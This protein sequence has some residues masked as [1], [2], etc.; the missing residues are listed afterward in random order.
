MSGRPGSCYTIRDLSGIPLSAVIEGGA[1]ESDGGHEPSRVPG[2]SSP[3]RINALK[4]TGPLRSLSVAGS[5]VLGQHDG[6]DSAR[7]E[8][9]AWVFGATGERGVVVDP[10]KRGGTESCPHSSPR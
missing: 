5:V 7:L 1:R 8:R 3:I 4:E 10:M 9:V 6:E 2:P